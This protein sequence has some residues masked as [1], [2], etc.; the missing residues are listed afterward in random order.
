MCAGATPADADEAVQESFLRLHQHLETRG[1][2]SNAPAWIFQVARNY[3]HDA[4]KSAHQQRTVPLDCDLQGESQLADPGVGPEIRA[5]NEERDRR[6][7]EAIQELPRQQRE[8]ILL[9]SAGLRYREIAGLLGINV[10][11][12]GAIMQRAVA[13]LNQ[14]LS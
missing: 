4:R 14:E 3:L 7:R 2:L 13:R 1:C 8:C 10:N 6:L 11:S 12:V 5:L 9:R